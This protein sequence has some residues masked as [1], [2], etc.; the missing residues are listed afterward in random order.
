MLNAIHP[1]L[2]MRDK[3]KTK[4]YYLNKLEFQAVGGDYPDYL[5]VKKDQIEIHFFQ[6]KNLD[7]KDNYGGNLYSN[8]PDRSII[9][10]AT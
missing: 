2:S 7:P 5:M 6:F 4:D 9:S 3:S 1:R 10:K 8:R